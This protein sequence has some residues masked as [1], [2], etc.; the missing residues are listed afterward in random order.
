VKDEGVVA[1]DQQ[2][3]TERDLGLLRRLLAPDGPTGPADDIAQ[4]LLE[5]V[6]ELIPC[7][8]VTMQV[9]DHPNRYSRTQS[10]CEGE[11]DPELDRLFWQGFWDCLACSYPQRTGRTDVTRSSDFEVNTSE[12]LAEVG[13]RHELVVPLPLPDRYDHRLVL[14]RDSGPDFTERDLL[15]MTLLQPH[16][17]EMHARQL[18]RQRGTPD[19]TPRQWEI[20]R[21]VAAGC[22][23]RQVARA[24]GLTERTVGKHLEN[25]YVR[26]GTQSRT[27]AIA[28]AG[29]QPAMAV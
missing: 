2:T 4:S 9:M 17:T 3:V 23:N 14:F 20:L 16:V 29:V 22:T 24:L 18:R 8:D 15:L 21:L 5:D 7:A 27:E 26:L 12:Y 19:L 28:A 10:T 13:M 1:M 6:A 25:I 11:D